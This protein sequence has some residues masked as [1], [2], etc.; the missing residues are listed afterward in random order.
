MSTYGR[1]STEHGALRCFDIVVNVDAGGLTLS[2]SVWL[3]STFFA[4]CAIRH[5][6]RTLR[7]P[8]HEVTIAAMSLSGNETVGR[9]DTSLGRVGFLHV[10]CHIVIRRYGRPKPLL[11]A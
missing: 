11:F 3:S 6:G 10:R 2:L 9:S 5:R 1:L 8:E 4:V 7:F